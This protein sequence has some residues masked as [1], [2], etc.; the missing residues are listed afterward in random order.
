MIITFLMFRFGSIQYL[1]SDDSYLFFPF[2]GSGRVSISEDNEYLPD[3][4]VEIANNSIP[5][6]KQCCTDKIFQFIDVLGPQLTKINR[7]PTDLILWMLNHLQLSRSLSP[8]H[9]MMFSD[10]I[11]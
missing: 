6:L 8:L 9:L 4:A 7:L 11:Q 2:N 1:C 3:L 5:S 10:A